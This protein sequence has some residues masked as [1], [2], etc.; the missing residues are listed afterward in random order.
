M[1]TSTSVPPRA[2]RLVDPAQASVR[3][4][5]GWMTAWKR[6]SQHPNRWEP[7]KN[8]LAFI[9]PCCAFADDP[10]ARVHTRPFSLLLWRHQIQRVPDDLVGAAEF[11]NQIA[12]HCD[13]P[14]AGHAGAAGPVVSH[15]RSCGPS[16]GTNFA[17]PVD[18]PEPPPQA[19]RT[20]KVKRIA[21]VFMVVLST[22]FRDQFG[23]C[24]LVWPLRR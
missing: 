19:V 17:G 7:C 22:S 13:T 15:G 10:I 1:K 14:D 4:S 9:R 18:V 11:E 3:P 20:T 5:P 16:D 21:M 12:F 6:L 24:G 8:G 23:D 2:A